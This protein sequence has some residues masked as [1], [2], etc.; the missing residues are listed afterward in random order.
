MEYGL[1]RVLSYRWLRA[2]VFSVVAMAALC[3]GVCAV[4]LARHRHA[5]HTQHVLL[6][7]LA[8]EDSGGDGVWLSD[9][10]AESSDSDGGGDCRSQDGDVAAVEDDQTSLL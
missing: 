3:V 4:R 8:A 7:Q 1:C 10:A 2:G 5:A 6:A 9:V